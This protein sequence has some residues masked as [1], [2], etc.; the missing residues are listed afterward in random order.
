MTK[1]TMHFVTTLEFVVICYSCQNS[2]VSYKPTADRTK[3]TKPVDSFLRAGVYNV[4]YYASKQMNGEEKALLGKTAQLIKTN[5]HTRLFFD[6]LSKGETP[7]FTTKMGLRKKEFMKLTGIFAYEKPK[8]A[9]GKLQIVQKGDFI[10]FKGGGALHLFDSVI[11]SFFLDHV[12]FRNFDLAND[13]SD[14][15]LSSALIPAGDTLSDFRLFEGPAGLSGLMGLNGKYQLIIGRLRPS[16][17]TYLLLNARK[18]EIME[19]AIPEYC[20]IIIERD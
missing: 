6:Q 17:R 11:I 7:A 10:G 2:A 1:I 16:G 19:H 12:Y 20:S 18:P 14:I 4:I 5:K 9:R 13:S 15:D 3:Q 8:E